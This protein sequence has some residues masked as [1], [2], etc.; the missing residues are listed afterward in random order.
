MIS[1]Y[2]YH[3]RTLFLI[4]LSKVLFKLKYEEILNINYSHFSRM[5]KIF[6]YILL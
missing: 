6:K 1:E 4:F 2:L 3:T 5:E